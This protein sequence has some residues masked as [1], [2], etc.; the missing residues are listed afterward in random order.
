MDPT[1]ITHCMENHIPLLVL[2]LWDETALGKALMGEKI[3]TL[4]SG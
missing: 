2:N 3:G 4:I 1:A